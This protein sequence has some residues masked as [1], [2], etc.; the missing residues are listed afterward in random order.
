M[1]QFQRHLEGLAGFQHTRRIS[2]NQETEGSADRAQH[3]KWGH[4]HTS[5]HQLVPGAAV[6]EWGEWSRCWVPTLWR[7]ALCPVPCSSPR[8]TGPRL[9]GVG[10]P[11]PEHPPQGVSNQLGCGRGATT[12]TTTR[13]CPR[14]G[15]SSGFAERHK[16]LSKLSPTPFNLVSFYAAG[17]IFLSLITPWKFMLSMLRMDGCKRQTLE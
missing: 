6:M 10:T 13:W 12:H 15:R 9:L 8:G 16:D 17:S 2:I 5:L 11:D 7:A 14:P 1:V 3:G 4:S